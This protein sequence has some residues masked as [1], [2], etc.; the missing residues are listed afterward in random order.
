MESSDYFRAQA[1]ECR[2]L[3]GGLAASRDRDGLLMLARH[4]EAE[5]KRAAA[6]T[7]QPALRTPA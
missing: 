1:H 4:Y 3:A 7:V 2:E 5:A 6:G